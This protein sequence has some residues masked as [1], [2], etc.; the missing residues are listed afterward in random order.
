MISQSVSSCEKR[1]PSTRDGM[2][3]MDERKQFCCFLFLANDRRSAADRGV[4]FFVEVLKKVGGDWEG[5]E[6]WNICV[7]SVFIRVECGGMS[8]IVMG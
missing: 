7:F 5:V 1:E 4:G 6:R 2:H 8:E 3:R